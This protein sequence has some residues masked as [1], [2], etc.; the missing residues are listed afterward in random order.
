MEQCHSPLAEA[1]AADPSRMRLLEAAQAIVLRGNKEFS[2][3]EL[4]AEAGVEREIFHDHFAGRTALMA[5]LMRDYP[6]GGP[7]GGPVAGPV[8]GSGSAP[9]AVA[10]AT[11]KP[12]SKAEITPEPSVTTPDEWFERRL[13]VFERALTSLEAKAE[14]TAREQARVIAE[15][16]ERLKENSPFESM[17]AP[18]QADA[19]T[20]PEAVS[21]A[22]PEIAQVHSLD[23]IVGTPDAVP[24]TTQAEMPLL[25]EVSL[26][27]PATEQPMSGPPAAESK[28]QESTSEPAALTGP[29]IG[30]A[31]PGTH[32]IP[33]LEAVQQPR[34]PKATMRMRLMAIAAALLV[35]AFLGVGFL[36]GRNV[37][38]VNAQARTPDG[39]AHRQMAQTT[40]HKTMALADAGDARAQARLALAYLRGQGSA[41]DADAA[42]LWCMS[43]AR[44]GN[45]VAQYLLGALYQQ[46]DHVAADPALAMNWFS[47]A[48]EKGNLKA[49]HNL[50]IA[51]AQGQ[52]TEKDEAKA[53]EWFTRAAE[54]GYVDSAFD[55]A[56]LYERGE[57]VP[58]DLKQALK[59]YGIAA[60]A[61][62][63]PSRERAD[64]LRSQMQAADIKLATNA[65]TAFAPLPALEEANSL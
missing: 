12:V 10:A 15:L 38:D 56:V 20:M 46:G 28:P 48:A 21:A 1:G 41:R 9:Q 24:E 17:S 23:P 65:A 30:D 25:D 58:Q 14:T 53:A 8:P 36:L 60:L 18:S 19:Q 52:G 32:N 11:P 54:R 51:Y 16:Q 6:F 34:P 42:L 26:K 37:L 2:V 22:L 57:G 13:R 35:A 63:R 62:D 7:V 39:V 27:E 55:L 49:M 31:L 50:A 47:R 44:A 43:A 33:D 40:L 4:C 45:P 61:G 5:A 29:V 59:W 3:A 64:F